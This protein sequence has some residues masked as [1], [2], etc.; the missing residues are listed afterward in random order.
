MRCRVFLQGIERFAEAEL[1][2]DPATGDFTLDSFTL[3]R[4]RYE[5]HG[6]SFSQWLY[7]V[8]PPAFRVAVQEPAYILRQHARFEHPCI[9]WVLTVNYLV[10]SC[11]PA[12]VRV[13]PRRVVLRLSPSTQNENERAY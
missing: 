7:L 9:V 12:G 4:T 6:G 5:C 1:A 3:G 10:S 8:H 2:R 11:D 13:E